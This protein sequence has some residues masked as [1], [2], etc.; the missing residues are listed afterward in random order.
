VNDMVADE[1][2]R[3]VV[4][5]EFEGQTLTGLLNRAAYGEGAI[6]NLVDATVFDISVTA[7]DDSTWTLAGA[8]S[9]ETVALSVDGQGGIAY[10]HSDASTYPDYAFVLWPLT[11]PDPLAPEWF[12]GFRDRNRR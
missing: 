12:A 3:P 10:H 4:L 9:S 7:H 11:C 1:Q 8:V 2:G 5:F 6:A